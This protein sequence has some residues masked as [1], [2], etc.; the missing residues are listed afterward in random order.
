MAGKTTD[1]KKKDKAPVA[2]AIENVATFTLPDSLP[3][4]EIEFPVLI[5]RVNRANWNL[6]VEQRAKELKEID[7]TW[8]SKQEPV[9]KQPF[10]CKLIALTT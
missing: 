9:I 8:Q 7:D 1:R 10:L 3:C 4:S 2:E 6:I 5:K